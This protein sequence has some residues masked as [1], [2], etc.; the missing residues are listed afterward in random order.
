MKL[1]GEVVVLKVAVPAP[2]SDI[3]TLPAFI[4]VFP[5]IVT[6][7]VPQVSLEVDDNVMVG[8][9]THPQSTLTVVTDDIQ[10]SEF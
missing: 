3:L 6:A 1:N 8:E 5:V 10:P 7:S 4:N 9:S 2:L